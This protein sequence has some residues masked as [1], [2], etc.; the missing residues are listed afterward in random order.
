MLKMQKTYARQG[1]TAPHRTPPHP[2]APPTAPST[3][4][5]R[6]PPHATAPNTVLATTVHLKTRNIIV[7]GVWSIVLGALDVFFCSAWRFTMICFF[8]A[9][10]NGWQTIWHLRLIQVAGKSLFCLTK[11]NSKDSTWF[12]FCGGLFLQDTRF[13]WFHNQ[14]RANGID[15]AISALLS[16]ILVSIAFFISNP[17][18]TLFCTPS[19][20][21]VE[22]WLA[23]SG[24]LAW[25]L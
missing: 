9:A 16:D 13:K 25:N 15:S 14:F 8:G 10:N 24:A 22:P 17:I 6:T 19:I 23:W 12:S 7:S 1:I 18:G 21:P 2:T 20:V 11:A 5:H 4:P 3:A